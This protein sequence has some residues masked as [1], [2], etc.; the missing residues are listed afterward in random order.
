V[1]DATHL[2][3]LDIGN[4]NT[5]I[6]VAAGVGPIAAYSLPTHDKGTADAWGF[7][8]ESIL[9]REGISAVNLEAVVVSS[10]VPPTNAL[11]KPACRRFFNRDPQFVPG[12]IALPLENRYERPG[13]VG[14]DRLVTAY[15]ARRLSTAEHIIVA[16]FGTATTF[17][18]VSGNAYMGGLICPG[19][20]SSAGALASRTAK[21]PQITLEL[22]EP[23]IQPGRSTADS[24]NQGFIFGF[25]SMAEGILARLKATLPGEVFTMAVGGFAEKVAAVCDCFDE[26]RPDVLLEGLRWAYNDSGVDETGT[27]REHI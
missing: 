25:A 17:D 22:T 11:L 9:K 21:L 5:K 16:D 13:E 15:A 6:G 1:S 10:V 3:L 2:L 20:L 4:T 12:D 18:V 14:A 19:V 7:A 24:L 23:T 8:L 27:S 26:V